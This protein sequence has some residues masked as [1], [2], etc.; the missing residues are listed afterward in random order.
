LVPVRIHEPGQLSALC[1]A[2]PCFSGT[3]Y[4]ILALQ[5]EWLKEVIIYYYN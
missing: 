5:A 2:F 4:V 3:L 1:P